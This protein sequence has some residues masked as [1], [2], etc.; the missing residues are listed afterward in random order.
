VIPR[1]EGRRILACTWTSNKFEGRAPDDVLLVRAFI[2]GDD[3]DPVATARQE[4]GA[5]MGLKG[6][7]TFTRAF[8]WPARNPVYAPGHERRM[9][10]AE[11]ALPRGLHLCGSGFHGAGLPD[12]IK[13]GRAVARR[14]LSEK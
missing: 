14:I 11:G 7:P 8:R 4:L 12:C 5:L 3:P 9:R 13:D 2:K 6:E 1:G 10:E